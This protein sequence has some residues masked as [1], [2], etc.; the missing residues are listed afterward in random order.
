MKILILGSNGLVGS[1]LKRTFDKEDSYS[2]LAST[3]SDTN[4]FSLEDTKNLI[5]NTKPVFW[6]NAIYLKNLSKSKIR[7]LG[8]FLQK[9]NIEVRSGFWPLQKLGFFKSFYVNSQRNYVTDKIFEKILV[10]PS[11]SNLKEREIKYIKKEID[12]Y[13]KINL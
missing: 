7:N 2:V 9:K 13:L 3:R 12:F 5:K 1:S 8:Y 11:N 10:L 4:L 6:L